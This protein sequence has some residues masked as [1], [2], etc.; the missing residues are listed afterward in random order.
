[1]SK[2]CADKKCQAI[3][4]Y[5]KI[6]KNCQTS[7][8][9]PVKPPIHMQSVTRSA[10]DK[11]YQATISYQ[12]QKKCEYDDSKSQ[13]TVNYDKNCQENEI[14]NMQPVKPEMN[15]WLFKP[16]IRRLCNDK[17]C[18]STRFLQEKRL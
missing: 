14:I 10:S 1:M 2:V 7:V 4:C 3:K 12:K 6:D 11:N 18:Q 13:S 16:A 17:N 9:W 8:K 15:V 5:K